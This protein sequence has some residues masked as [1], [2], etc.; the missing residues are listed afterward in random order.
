M[1]QVKTFLSL[2][3][4]TLEEKVNE[5]LEKESVEVINTNFYYSKGGCYYIVLTYKKGVG[6]CL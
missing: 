2:N 4:D 5:F 6:I 3:L 1:T